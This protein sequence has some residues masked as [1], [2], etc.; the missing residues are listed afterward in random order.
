MLL[1]MKLN[2]E[3]MQLLVQKSKIISKSREI[4][5]L[6]NKSKY[7]VLHW[8]NCVKIIIKRNQHL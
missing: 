1:Y 2:Q 7:Q 3:Q 8:E 6:Q 5:V 4:Q